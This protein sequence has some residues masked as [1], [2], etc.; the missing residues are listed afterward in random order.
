MHTYINI[1][2]VFSIEDDG[3]LDSLTLALVYRSLL[4]QL[5]EE[6]FLLLWREFRLDP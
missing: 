4:S 2:L 6:R 1:E 5:L 3:V